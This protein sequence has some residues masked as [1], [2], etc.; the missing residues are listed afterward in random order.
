MI[1]HLRHELLCL[2]GLVRMTT[3]LLA[4]HFAGHSAWYAFSHATHAVGLDPAAVS[5]VSGPAGIPVAIVV[6]LGGTKA[7][8]RL[9]ARA[10]K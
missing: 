10:A 3:I 6:V 9:R 7:E 8:E 4:G 1:A 5:A 2:P